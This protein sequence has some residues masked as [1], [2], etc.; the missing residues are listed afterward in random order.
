MSIV[1]ILGMAA[2]VSLLSGWRLYLCIFVTG[3]A[4]RF[5]IWPLPE[6]LHAPQ[7]LA[8]P[9]VLGVAGGAALAEF[10]ADKVVWI[11]SIWDAVHTIIRPLGGAMLALALI[12]PRDPST[13]VIAFILGGGASLLTH[14]AKA[15]TRAIANTVPEP[16]SNVALSTGEDLTST[17]L[18][19]FAYSHP[20]SAAFVAVA[21]AAMAVVAIIWLRRVLRRLRRVATTLP[22]VTE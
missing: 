21:L 15:G 5:G 9:V 20:A 3:L 19:W 12:D 2:S 13:Q 18:L 14:T 11:D 7:V 16:F 6:H 8:N 22:A 1:E 4:L 17:G 10:L